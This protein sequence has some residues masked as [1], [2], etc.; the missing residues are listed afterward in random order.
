MNNNEIIAEQVRQLKTDF[1]K[2]KQA[3]YEAGYNAGYTAGKSEGGDILAAYQQGLV[4]GK[5]AE[6][7]AFW[8]AYQAYGS[9]TDYSYAFY[10]WKDELFN[11]KY[12]FVKTR[13]CKF[14]YA[15]YGSTIQDLSQHF[16]K[17]AAFQNAFMNSCVTKVGGVHATVSNSQLNNAFFG[18]TLLEEIG[19]ISCIN[20]TYFTG[21]FSGCSELT[22]IIFVQGSKIGRSISFASSSKLSSDSV[23]SIFKS[24]TTPVATNQTLTFHK[25]TVLT[26]EQK[27]AA[28]ALG[29]QIVQ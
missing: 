1:D 27:D 7:D 24:L 2:V 28:L 3:G 5:Q 16:F 13:T 14:P 23:D 25:D 22:K 11:P 21:A 26:Q 9:R 20:S 12:K 19:E 8:D 10:N 29:W 15:F 17:S 4:D 6:Y 18:C